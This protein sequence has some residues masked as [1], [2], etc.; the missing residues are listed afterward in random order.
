[1]FNIAEDEQDRIPEILFGGRVHLWHIDKPSNLVLMGDGYGFA[2]WNE[3]GIYGP[4]SLS[5]VSLVIRQDR[6]VAGTYLTIRWNKHRNTTD[7]DNAM[8][9]YFPEYNAVDMG[10]LYYKRDTDA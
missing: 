10:Y 8:S 2:V 1:M 5:G 4:Y 7:I 3:N 9:I 6:G